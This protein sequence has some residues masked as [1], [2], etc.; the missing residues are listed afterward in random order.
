ME[1]SMM[2]TILLAL[3]VCL[4][5][6]VE[7]AFAGPGGRI[8][9]V[10][11]ETFWGKVALGALT[12]V[13]FPVIV[14]V[15]VQEYLAQRRAHRDLRFMARHSPAFEW[16]RLQ[17]RIKDCFQRVHSSWEKEDLSDVGEWMTEWYWQNQQLAHLERWKREGL[18]NIC[19]V[20][21]IK[22]I[23]PLLFVHSNHGAEHEGSM[24]AVSIT[25]VMK[26]YLQQRSSGKVVEGSRKFKEVETIW[27][28]T[29]TDEKWRVSYIDE[30]SSSLD[31]AARRAEL[32]PIETTV[33]THG[34]S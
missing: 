5:I 7:P 26:D 32:P 11:F 8:A 12:V 27:T 22:S 14:W 1:V 21:K 18:Q 24:L 13:L 28:F 25:A 31:L 34:R 30:G 29:L 10:A 2:K 16:L 6:A 23:K 9:R 4:L 20:K 3:A 33:V 17:S 19:A 15:T